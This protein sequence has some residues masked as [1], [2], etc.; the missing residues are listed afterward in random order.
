MRSRRRY[1]SCCS[2]QAVRP[3]LVPPE[4]AAAN[5][6]PFELFSPPTEDVVIAHPVLEPVPVVIE[7][8]PTPEPIVIGESTIPPEVLREILNEQ[9][10][11]PGFSDGGPPPD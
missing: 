1:R 5:D 2:A 9:L 3:L 8:V 11:S 10:I 7:E 4:V 6:V